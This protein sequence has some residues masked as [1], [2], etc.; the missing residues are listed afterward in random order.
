M[1]EEPPALGIDF[2][3]TNTVVASADGDGRVSLREFHKDGR[4]EFA[5]RSVLSFWQ[6]MQAGRP[7]RKVDSGPW[8]I[9]RFVADPHD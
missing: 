4:D 3:T 8:A 6:E 7:E 9:D 5:Y 1:A 2:G